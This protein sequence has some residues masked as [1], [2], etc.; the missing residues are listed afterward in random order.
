[1]A[2]YSKYFSVSRTMSC[3]CLHTG[4][5]GDFAAHVDLSRRSCRIRWNAGFT[6]IAGNIGSIYDGIGGAAPRE[7]RRFRCHFLRSLLSTSSRKSRGGTAGTHRNV[8]ADFSKWNFAT[9]PPLY[10]IRSP[11]SASVDE[12]YPGLGFVCFARALKP[13]RSE[14][15]S[16][17]HAHAYP[18]VR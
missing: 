17:T 15:R 18:T 7:I 10:L 12:K 14:T 8:L 5:F 16:C 3:I 6:A 1:M 4:Y 2:T 11:C 9:R 13:S